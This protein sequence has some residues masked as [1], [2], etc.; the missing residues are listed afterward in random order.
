MKPCSGMARGHAVLGRWLLALLLAAAGFAATARDMATPAPPVP[1]LWKVQ[2]DGQSLWLLGAFHMLAA[3]DYPLSPDV[4]AA[5]AAATRVVFELPP[6]EANSPAL[7]AAM[8]QAATLDDGRSLQ[9]ALDADTWRKLGD[10]C[11]R[12]GVPREALAR[13]QAW[14]VGLSVGI[15]SMARQGLQPALGLDRHFMAAA[16]QAGKPTAGL[17]TARG[18]IALLAGMSPGEQAQ[19]LAES[20][21]QSDAGDAEARALHD[22]WRRGDADGLWNGMAGKMRR[23]YP[24][25]YRR[26]N[27]ERNDRWLPAIER[28]LHDGQGDALVIVG[29][30]HL[31]GRDGVVEKLRAKGYAVQRVCTACAAAAVAPR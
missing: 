18:Q 19:M 29:S 15:V 21:D 9:D 4:D 3:T 2:G 27:V 22:A 8:L 6:D 30:L 11:A 12:N 23:D 24:A 13:Y 20:L 17:E 28:Y 25:L 1:L 14:F 16:A 26:I 7:Q 5:F 31:L 10:W